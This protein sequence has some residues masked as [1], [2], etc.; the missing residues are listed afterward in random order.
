[1]GGGCLGL[2]LPNPVADPSPLPDRRGEIPGGGLQQADRFDEI[3]LAGAV[4]TDQ[5][6]QRPQFQRLGIRPE[7][8]QA[9]RFDT[10][11]QHVC[12]HLR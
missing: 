8:E 2:T 9:L 7:R 6:I 10:P 4:G 11:Y 3:G 5:D 12:V 1:M